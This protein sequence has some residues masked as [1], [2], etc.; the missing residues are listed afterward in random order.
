MTVAAPLLNARA[1]PTS[2][3]LTIGASGTSGIAIALLLMPRL[4]LSGTYSP[5]VG[6]TN[7]SLI[8]SYV[9][10]TPAKRPRNLPL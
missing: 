1:V 3:A 4:L 7:S 8:G 6:V 9:I 10:P 2:V 5:V